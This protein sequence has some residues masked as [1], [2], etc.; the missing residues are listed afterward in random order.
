[1]EPKD[2]ITEARLINFLKKHPNFFLHNPKILENLNLSHKVNGSVSLL[3]KQASV[4]RDKIAT[5]T[6]TLQQQELELNN[7]K[8]QL[9]LFKD[10]AIDL[11][12]QNPFSCFKNYLKINFNS[13]CA[14]FYFIDEY[15]NKILSID[16]KYRISDNNNVTHETYILPAKEHDNSFLQLKKSML[17]ASHPHLIHIFP[18]QTNLIKS[19]AF[20][21]IK[22]N[23]QNIGFIAIGSY[24][25]HQFKDGQDGYLLSLFA[26]LFYS[27]LNLMLNLLQDKH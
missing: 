1:M 14:N 12:K 7:H 5:L 8:K 22:R 11:M 2:Q 20:L 23:S 6:S 24:Y 13:R 10:F 4:L 16:S 9:G 25:P 27:K 3:E 17:F 26:E 15:L 18:E 19:C 21:P